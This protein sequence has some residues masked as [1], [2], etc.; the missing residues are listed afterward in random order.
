MYTQKELR[1]ASIVEEFV[2]ASGCP[3]ESEAIA[4]TQDGNIEGM[5]HTVADVKAFYDIYGPPVEYVRSRTTKKR[6]VAQL[7]TDEGIREQ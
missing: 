2:R 7:G 6:S 1:K 4:M 3:T 5:P